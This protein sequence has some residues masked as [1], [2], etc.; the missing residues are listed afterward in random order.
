MD[1]H[2]YIPYFLLSMEHHDY[3][4]MLAVENGNCKIN[5]NLYWNAAEKYFSFKRS[6]KTLGEKQRLLWGVKTN[7]K[8]CGLHSLVD[9]INTQFLCYISANGSDF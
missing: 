2:G 9:N 3:H 5:S 8:L 4:F 7:M 1:E 6:M